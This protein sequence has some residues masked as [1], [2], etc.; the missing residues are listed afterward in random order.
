MP[1]PML[2]ISLAIFAASALIEGAITLAVVEALDAIQPNFVRKP[3]ERPLA[4]V[5]LAVT[6]VLLGAVGVMFASTAPDGIEHLTRIQ[7]AGPPERWLGKTAA[8][9]GGLALIYAACL[10]IGRLAVRSRAAA[11]GSA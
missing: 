4:L 10:V 11:G 2:A 8:G 9:L 7:A 1:R 3:A 5:A 6:A